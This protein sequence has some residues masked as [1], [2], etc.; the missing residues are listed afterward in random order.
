MKVIKEKETW[1]HVVRSFSQWDAAH[2]WGYFAAF[3][4]REP[5]SEP[6]LFFHESAAGRVAYP[7][8]CCRSAEFAELR[9]VYGYTGPL[10][11]GG[12]KVWK[13]FSAA[14]SDFCSKNQVRQI[15]ER[16]HPLLAND[17]PLFDET[18]KRKAREVVIIETAPESVLEESY[19]RKDKRRGMKRAR[20]HGIQ[21]FPEGIEHLE[22]FLELYY[23]TMAHNQA[24]EIYY[25]EREFFLKLAEEFNERLVLFNAYLE[26]EIIESAL[27]LYTPLCAYSFLTARD[28][29]YGSCHANNLV[30]QKAYAY[31]YEL[32]IPRVNEGGGRTSDPEDSLFRFKQGFTKK[33]STVPE[34]FP[35]YQATTKL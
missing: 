9:A 28:V 6:L 21:V 35:Y 27:Y 33:N 1:N 4:L 34:I 31:F 14:L 19:C 30:S 3:Q 11:E 25:F 5:Q 29:A 26:N 13:E 15:E 24:A 8:L 2:E 7:F 10:I 12:Q 18:N 23:Q 22:R 32:G 16:F 17:Y 20:K